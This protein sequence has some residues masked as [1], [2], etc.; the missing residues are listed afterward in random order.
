MNNIYNFTQLKLIEDKYN[1][2]TICNSTIPSNIEE[3]EKEL[4]TILQNITDKKLLWIKLS[5]EQSHFIPS[6]TKNGFKF[7]DCETQNLTLLKKLINDPIMPTATNHTLGVGAIVIDNGELLVIKD[8]FQE[9]YKLPGGHIDD[10]ENISQALQREIIEETG[11]KV[12]FEAIVS[13]GHFSPGQFGES[14]LYILCRAKAL[15]KEIN[16]Q[17]Y[18]EIIDAKWIKL[19]DYL[20][21]EDVHVYNKDIVKASLQNDGLKLKPTDIFKNIDKQYELFF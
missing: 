11:V 19:E 20:E 15:S 21:S 18:E 17:D 8:R 7:Y 4:D 6:L 5:I 13:L 2:I 3:F 10:R 16:I 1:G 14:N 12:Q 9:G